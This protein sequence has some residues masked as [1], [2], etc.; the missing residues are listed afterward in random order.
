MRFT[1]TWLL[2]PHRIGSVAIA[3]M[4]ATAMPACAASSN[5]SVSTTE[6]QQDTEQ[7]EPEVVQEEQEQPVERQEPIAVKQ[8]EPLPSYNEMVANAD[9]LVGNKYHIAGRVTHVGG[10][11]RGDD[12][13]VS[14]Y[15]DESCTQGE[16]AY[17]RIPYKSYG[18][19]V[20]RYFEGDCTFEGLNDNGH[21]QFVCYTYRTEQQ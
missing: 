4:V 3:A 6:V 14:V 17:I 2:T 13:E 18:D 21:P 19:S 15:W 9:S 10:G 20:N 5:H 8:V 11:F 12:Y 7:A 1:K 16:I